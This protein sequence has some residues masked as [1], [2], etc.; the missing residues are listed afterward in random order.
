MRKSLDCDE[1]RRLYEFC[2]EHEKVYLYG[3]GEFGELYY[4][5]LTEM[6]GLKGK[7]VGF[8]DSNKEGEKC[9]LPILCID[10]EDIKWGGG[11]CGVIISTREQYVDEILN[12]LPSK[13]DYL[14]FDDSEICSIQEGY[15]DFFIKRHDLDEDLK[16]KLTINGSYYIQLIRTINKQIN[17][18]RLNYYIEPRLRRFDRIEIDTQA[19]FT[20]DD[21]AII[22]QGPIRYDNSFTYNTL[23]VYRKIYPNVLIIVSTWK[24]EVTV[25]FREK[26]MEKRIVIMENEYP[27]SSGVKHVNYQLLSSAKGVEYTLDKE[28]IKYVLKC[29]TDQRINKPDFLLYMR[30]LLQT[31]PSGGIL[32]DRIV[33]S[34]FFDCPFCIRDFLMFGN[35]KDLIKL[36]TIPH[37]N[38]KRLQNIPRQGIVDKIGERMM[39]ETNRILM[40]ERH[41]EI[42][43]KKELKDKTVNIKS[44]FKYYNPEIYIFR[45]FYDK[46]IEKI[47]AERILEQ[48]RCFLKE[49]ICVA[50][51]D[52]LELYWDKYEGHSFMSLRQANYY[53]WLNLLNDN[54]IK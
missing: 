28:S 23:S 42:L 52:V 49:L 19:R 48:Y 53:Y 26:C 2:D 45:T 47:D 35:K 50:D 33:V 46:N 21:I 40:K 16:S 9:G 27:R 25:D 22:I 17:E 37:D 36:F 44:L 29:R 1:I 34:D 18:N 32:K 8:L 24:G 4:C 31:Y 43:R 20:I 51:L 15:F 30:N 5:V 39:R 54:M 13:T 10:S 12:N 7:I 3:A 6:C 14:F 41:G 38:N 11:R